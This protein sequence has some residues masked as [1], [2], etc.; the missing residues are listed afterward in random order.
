MRASLQVDPSELAQEAEL[1]IIGQRPWPVRTREEIQHLFEACGFRI[2]ELSDAPPTAPT[3]Q[4][5]DG[6]AVAGSGERVQII[7]TRL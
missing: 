7:A 4:Q 6:P 1:Y 3:G 2:D 5:Q